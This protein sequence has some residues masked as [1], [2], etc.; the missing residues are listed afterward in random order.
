M[1]HPTKSMNYY[2][3]VMIGMTRTAKSTVLGYYDT[4]SPPTGKEYKRD[5][6][7]DYMNKYV[8]IFMC[9]IRYPIK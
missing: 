7:P 3:Y 2:N 1:K 4:N 8:D 6:P 9:K 5:L